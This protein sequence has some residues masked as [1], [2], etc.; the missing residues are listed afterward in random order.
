[1]TD[2]KIHDG[3]RVNSG[4]FTCKSCGKL[5]RQVAGCYNKDYCP[6]CQDRLEHENSH[7]DN[8][9]PDDDCGDPE[10]PIKAYTKE[11]RWWLS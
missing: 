11:Q 3:F 5:T 4:C 9:F 1:M 10:C 8:D 6:I 7:A 2:D